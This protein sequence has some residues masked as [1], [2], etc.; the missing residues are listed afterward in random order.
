MQ[1]PKHHK[2]GQNL[3]YDKHV[4]AN[5]GVL[6]SG[7]EHDTLL[8]S[9]VLE[10]HQSHDM[11]S[12]AA[13]HLGVKT[14]SYD[15][16]TGKGASRIPFEQVAVERATEYSG[17]DADMTLQLHRTLYPQVERDEKLDQRLPQHRNA[18]DGSAVHDGTPGRAARLRAAG[19][20]EPRTWAKR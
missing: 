2:V 19:A 9:Y 16:V 14:I 7:I 10:S 17:E 6:L 15:E 3:K 1:S 8:Q 18:G 13:R 12:L 11:D 20:A 4:F 5:H